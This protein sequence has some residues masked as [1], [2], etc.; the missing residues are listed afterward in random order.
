MVFDVFSFSLPLSNPLRHPDRLG[1][2]IVTRTLWL[3][4]RERQCDDGDI[5]VPTSSSR[6]FPNTGALSEEEAVTND[7]HSHAGLACLGLT[8][9]R[10]TLVPG[11][12]A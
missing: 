10:L 9:S 7:I 4:F 8:K 11:T 12:K 2:S 5:S 3:A 6:G 1:A